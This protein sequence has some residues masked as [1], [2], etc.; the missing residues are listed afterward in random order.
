MNTPQQGIS[1]KGNTVDN[2]TRCI[3]YHTVLDIVAIKMPCC[4]TYYTCIQCHNETAGH[5][6][7]IWPREAFDT[8]AVLCGECYR[9]MTIK[10]YLASNNQ[11]P[12][13]NAAFNPK[14]CN[15]YHLYFEQ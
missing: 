5:P 11:C 8:P 4:S 6:A 9:E 2:H 7:A 12:F 1:I 13:C 15:H 14:C 10:E 3:H